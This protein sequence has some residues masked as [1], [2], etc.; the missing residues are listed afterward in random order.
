MVDEQ[1]RTLL[2]EVC[3]TCHAEDSE[4]MRQSL[5]DFKPALRGVT[6][7]CVVPSW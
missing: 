4:V 2:V 5:R 1:K 7:R 6:P 3:V